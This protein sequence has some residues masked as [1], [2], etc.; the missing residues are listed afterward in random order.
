MRCMSNLL[1]TGLV[2]LLFC[3]PATGGEVDLNVIEQLADADP[4]PFVIVEASGKASKNRAQGVVISSKGHVL[5]AGHVAWVDAEKAFTDRFRIS[6]RGT[7]KGLPGKAAHIH[8]LVF[9]DREKA[10]FVERYFAAT[11]QRQGTSRFVDGGDLALFQIK[12]E[13]TFPK[14]DFF[15]QD[16]PVVTAGDILH[17]CHFTFPHKAGDPF[18]LISPLEVA[19]VANTSSGFQ[20]LAKGYYRVGSSGGA[21]LKNGRLIGIQSSAYTVN[22]KNIGEIPLGLISFQLVWGEMFKG[23]LASPPD[24]ANAPADQGS[25]DQPTAPVNSNVEGKESR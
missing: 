5:S 17:L 12:A 3:I 2:F 22:A 21:I 15:S 20:Y 8:K 23:L 4:K 16:K 6:F 24:N 7:G 1:G 25:V 14:L 13:G 19:G 18:F 11:L 9:S 10:T